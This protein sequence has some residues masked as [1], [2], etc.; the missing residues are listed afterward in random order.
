MTIHTRL[1][2]ERAA[3]LHSTW[4]M[5]TIA[6]IFGLFLISG[7]L[8]AVE[9]HPYRRQYV[10]DT[11]GKR[12]VGRVGAHALIGEARNAPKEWGRGPA[13]FGKR[14]ASGMATHVVKN[15]IEFPVAA[16]RHEDLQYHRSTDRRF[17]PRLRH[18]LVSTVVTTN[19]RNGRRTPAAGRISGS[20]GAGLISRA[21][22][23]AAART[24][25]GG[26]ATGGIMLGA[27][28][29]ANVAREFWPRK[30]HTRYRRR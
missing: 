8:G 13:G 17:G 23:P 20:M 11:Y 30:P 25:A 27:D 28:A 19:T 26:V 6:I 7:S 14:L 3:R 24:V 2:P 12:A 21:W 1:G 9:N 5:R 18:A 10:R 15:S 22:Q 16:K 4:V 29:G